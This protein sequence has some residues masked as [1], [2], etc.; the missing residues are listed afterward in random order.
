MIF[1]T[2]S[3]C[4]NLAHETWYKFKKVLEYNANRISIRVGGPYSYY[5]PSIS[6]LSR[7]MHDGIKKYYFLTMRDVEPFKLYE[8]DI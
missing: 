1:K 3:E 5:R 6:D 7:Y 4:D 8:D 2:Y